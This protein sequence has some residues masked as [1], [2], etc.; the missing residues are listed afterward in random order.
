MH[1]GI[2]TECKQIGLPLIAIEM[3][4]DAE[5]HFKEKGTYTYF[6]HISLYFNN[7]DFLTNITWQL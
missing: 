2:S 7:I 6:S 4:M 3:R 5:K 1:A